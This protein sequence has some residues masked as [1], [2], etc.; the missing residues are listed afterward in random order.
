MDEDQTI[1]HVESLIVKQPVE[2]VFHQL[3]DRFNELPD[4]NSS[5]LLIEGPPSF[6]LTEG[7]EFEGTFRYPYT[8]LK[9]KLKLRIHT[10]IPNQR[11]TYEAEKGSFLPVWNFFVEEVSLERTRITHVICSRQKGAFFHKVRLPILKNTFS[12]H[13]P[14]MLMQFKRRLEQLEVGV[15]V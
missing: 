4:W 1:I 12:T 11:L 8:I 14:K 10:I 2:I 15:G 5:C 6:Q 9:K 3:T 7:R 13:I